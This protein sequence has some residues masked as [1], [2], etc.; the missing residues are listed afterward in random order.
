MAFWLGIGLAMGGRAG[1]PGSS[2]WNGGDLIAQNGNH[3]IT[4]GGDQ[5]ITQYVIVSPLLTENANTLITEAGDTL[6]VE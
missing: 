1:V 2:P 6:I 3:L 5:L 4:E